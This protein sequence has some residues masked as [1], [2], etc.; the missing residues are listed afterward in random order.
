MSGKFETRASPASS[1]TAA[2]HLSGIKPVVGCVKVAMYV[3]WLWFSPLGMGGVYVGAQRAR[4]STFR[5]ASSWLN[6]VRDHPP[7]ALCGSPFLVGLLLLFDLKYVFWGRGLG[8]PCGDIGPL[9]R[10]PGLALLRFVVFFKFGGRLVDSRRRHRGSSAIRLTR[11]AGSLS[12]RVWT[13]CS[14]STA[15][16]F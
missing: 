9:L 13:C 7:A 8:L 2:P 12:L 6:P 14:S 10:L 5:L 11:C 1:P 15:A 16:V 3:S 4:T